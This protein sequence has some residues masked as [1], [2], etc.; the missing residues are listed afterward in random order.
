[1]SP[2]R[3]LPHVFI[4][5]EDDA[6]RQLANGFLLHLSTRRLQVLPEAG[7]WIGVR[8]RFASGHVVGMRRYGGRHMVLLIDFDEQSNR[9]QEVRTAIPDD[10]FNRVFVL[11]AWSEPEALRRADLGSYE[12]IGKAMAEDCRTGA[13][14]IWAHDL[15]Q[16]NEGELIRLRQAVFGFLFPP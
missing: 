7:G 16:H 8:E 2:N 12:T 13:R 9:L 1:M 3:Y 10:L 4:L 15:L 6:N 11:G 14:T 5:P